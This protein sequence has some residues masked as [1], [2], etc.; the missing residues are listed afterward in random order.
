MPM[1]PAFR[2]IEFASDG[3]TIR[4]RLYLPD[5]HP[6]PVVIMAHGFSATIPM[7][8]DKYAEQFC[9]RGLAALAFDHRG[10]GSSDGEPR[11]EINVWVQARGYIDAIG[12][13]RGTSKIGRSPVVLWS[14]SLSARVALGVAALDDRVDALVCQVPAFGDEPGTGDPDGVR[15]DA[16]RRFLATG[17]V[18][19]PA[20]AWVRS[21]VVSA[22]QSTNPSALEPLTAFRWFIDYGGRYGSGWTNRVVFTGPRDAPDYDPFACAPAVRVPVMFAMSPNDEME[23][24]NS[25]VA[26]ALFDRLPGP[27]ELL[28]VPGGHFGI[29]EHPSHAFDAAS[30]AQATWLS[31]AVAAIS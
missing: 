16:M 13:A 14:D 29:I 6:A 18:R 30:E 26:R 1:T 12:F 31:R 28:E 15:L 25:Q 17:A 7:T 21:A 19:R 24:A 11:G 20:D 27:K 3:A 9:E 8:L 22:D 10:H 2:P 23:G 4:G 5:D